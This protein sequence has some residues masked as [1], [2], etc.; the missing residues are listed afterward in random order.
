MR[1]L[2]KKISMLMVLAMLV[3]LFS[4]VV[5]ASAASKWSFYD[6]E[7]KE[8]VAKG[9]TYEMEKNQYANFDLYCEGEEADADTYSYYWESSDP[10]VVYVDK[11]NGR[12]RADKYGK[13]EAGDKAVISVYI[14]NKTTA[15][16][17]NAK[18]SFTIEIVDDADYA[19]VADFADEVFAVGQEYD[20]AAV[21]TADGKE[22]EAEVA[23][24]VDGKA[25]EGKF[26]PAE[27]T[28]YTVVVTATVDGEVVA[29][30]DYVITAEN[31]DAFE[32]EQVSL[33]SFTMTFA[34]GKD[35][36]K[37]DKND[38]YV[39]TSTTA[40]GKPFKTYVSKVEAKDN[41]LTVTLYNDLA[42]DT[43]V[44]VKYLDE[45]NGY[46]VIVGDVYT[47]VIETTKAKINT[48]TDVVI[49]L[50]NEQGFDITTADLLKKVTLENLDKNVY[51][52]TGINAAGA[53][54]IMYWAKDTSAEIKAIY[55]TRTYDL[56]N[57]KEV[58]IESAPAKIDFVDE[59]TTLIDSNKW[60]VAKV[61]TAKKD[62]AWNSNNKVSVSDIGGNQYQLYVEYSRVKTA[63][64]EKKDT[65]LSTELTLT[66]ESSSPDVLLVGA[67]GI[68]S[69]IKQGSADIIVKN[70]KEIIGVYSV[71]VV[72]AR[73][74]TRVVVNGS[75]ASVVS[76]NDA[77]LQVPV[78]VYDQFDAV[79]AGNITVKNVAVAND[80]GVVYTPANG[81]IAIGIPALAAGTDT[82]SYTYSLNCGN[83]AIPAYIG[84][85][86]NRPKA[87]VASYSFNETN[88]EVKLQAVSGNDAF[89]TQFPN[90][91]VTVAS[92]DE[93]GLLISS[94][95]VTSTITEI[96]NTN[97]NAAN[98]NF[99]FTVAADNNAAKAWVL[100]SDGL[101]KVGA[102]IDTTTAGTISFKTAVASGS[103]LSV[104]PAGTY[105]FTLFKGV[106]TV[107]GQYNYS[108]CGTFTLVVKDIQKKY[109]AVLANDQVSLTGAV[110]GGA[111][112]ADDIAIIKNAY[113]F[114]FDGNAVSAA[115]EVALALKN[116]VITA[117]VGAKIAYKEVIVTEI[118]S[119]AGIPYT[120][121][122]TIALNNITL[123]CK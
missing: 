70:G 92:R 103:A 12:L 62:L 52:Q 14:D 71:E 101:P 32:V 85:A 45:T 116:A 25:L 3:S 94:N 46:Q 91:S 42:K 80:N 65:V 60:T 9:D 96:K 122:S 75:Y 86:V 63:A 35:L 109:T 57:G 39:G 47:V 98:G 34:E 49:K 16:N 76:A 77:N 67:N 23:I 58:T 102:T 41:V 82:A 73:K 107:A 99:F 21:V 72:P 111:I 50:Y 2:S 53:P 104:A 22:I 90:V 83:D 121:D 6:R 11:T 29:T 114:N 66:Y 81:K 26:V 43:Y 17:E 61:G 113:N 59:V 19:I 120:L 68:L 48:Y 38:I 4:G 89:A 51:V 5:S 110:S 105:T 28:D 95:S 37:I 93:N 55:H 117:E 15:K 79:F 27:A 44:T 1:K 112:I 20:L 33:K 10:E 13:A 118:F 97:G 64:S 36:S 74:A 100:D 123:T 18:R 78:V 88:K 8:V 54:T 87:T 31:F 106:E 7:A 108:Y 84:F 115:N 30:E 69:P 24:T 40:D 119:M 56:A